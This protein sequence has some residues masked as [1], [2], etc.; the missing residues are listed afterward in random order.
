MWFETEDSVG[1]MIRGAHSQLSQSTHHAL[2][3]PFALFGL[4]RS[5]NFVQSLLAGVPHSPPIR[6]G[7]WHQIVPNAR[8][9]LIPTNEGEW[10]S[11]LFLTP[12]RLILLSVA[13]L[14]AICFVII[15]FIAAL[16]WRERREDQIERQRDSHKFHF[17]AM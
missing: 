16:H 11:R 14:G 3:L 17:D 12:S 9:Y 6:N 8:L 4:G 10:I 5:P 13:A 1:R 7:S 2:Q 15:V